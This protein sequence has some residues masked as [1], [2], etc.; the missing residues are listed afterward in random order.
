[1]FVFNLICLIIFLLIAFSANAIVPPGLD[2]QTPKG[3]TLINTG[4][5]GSS[6]YSIDVPDSTYST[7]PPMLINLTA[8]SSYE[9]GFR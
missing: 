7:L 2:T 3:Y 5:Y 1:M 9:Q 8:K 6:L 4:T